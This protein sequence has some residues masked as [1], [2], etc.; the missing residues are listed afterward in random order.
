MTDLFHQRQQQS[1]YVRKSEVAVQ[2]GGEAL[3]HEEMPA[4]LL[5]VTSESHASLSLSLATTSK[6]SLSSH[7]RWQGAARWKRGWNGAWKGWDDISATTSPIPESILD[8]RLTS[9]LHMMQDHLQQT[10]VI[11]QRRLQKT[12]SERSASKTNGNAACEAMEAVAEAR[13]RQEARRPYEQ[14][15]QDAAEAI[16]DTLEKKTERFGEGTSR[17]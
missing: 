12:L 2:Y 9:A 15:R 5:L 16:K 8:E 10:I 13:E 7:A 17:P 1:A 14:K 3:S 11:S 6:G 4:A